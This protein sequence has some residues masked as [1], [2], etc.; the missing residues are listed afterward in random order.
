MIR[1][2]AVLAVVGCLMMPAEAEEV[3]EVTVIESPDTGDH[4]NPVFSAMGLILSGLGL[5]YCG[6]KIWKK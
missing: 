2:L 3:R 4:M 1:G 5:Y 6:E